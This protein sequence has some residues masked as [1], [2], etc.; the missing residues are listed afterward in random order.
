[1]TNEPII[2]LQPAESAGA[3]GAG[4]RRNDLG[5]RRWAGGGRL[6]P[7]WSRA[8]VPA[9]AAVVAGTIGAVI[10]VGLI[11]QVPRAARPSAGLTFAALAGIAAV[12][13]VLQA[14][15]REAI[16]VVAYENG[17]VYSLAGTTGVVRWADVTAV[18]EQRF[19]R[20]NPL[21][22]EV[23][24]GH[25]FLF[26]CQDGTVHELEVGGIDDSETL[27]GYVHQGSLEF[28]IPRAEADLSAGRPVTFGPLSATPPGLVC[29][30]DFLVWDEMASIE[31]IA[32]RLVIGRRGAEAAWFDGPT[33]VIPNVHLLLNLI[34]AR[35]FGGEKAGGAGRSRVSLLDRYQ[36]S[37]GT[38]RIGF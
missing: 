21:G 2:D 1:M 7:D 35:F 31:V 34:D 20:V 10:A 11:D 13:A 27:A 19:T 24:R 16:A 12:T 26:E 37:A 28:L 14:R 22:Q 38:P 17:L 15:R 4:L 3:G 33:L 25:Q 18:S 29:G 9:V 32:G 6:P 8:L 5:G 36:P 30:T 23:G